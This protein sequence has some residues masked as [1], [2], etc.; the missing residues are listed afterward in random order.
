MR[1]PGGKGGSFR[2]L[3]NLM[4]RH[5]V[6]IETHL[7]GGAVIRRKR[8]VARNIGI[9]LDDRVAA[10]WKALDLPWLELVHGDAH[11]FLE[12]FP[13]A[14]SE[15]VFCDPPYLPET[16]RADRVYRYDYSRNDH[17]RLLDLL[18]G[19]PCQVMVCGYK[20]ALYDD[21]LSRWH[22]SDIHG[23]S[24]V[25]G[26]VD[27]V[28]TN[29]S[30]PDIPFDLQFAGHTYRERERIQRKHARLTQKIDGLDELERALLLDWL[31]EKYA[32][33]ASPKTGQP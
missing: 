2:R 18:R 33:P 10:R 25:G 32:F 6:Y 8:P 11:Q 9:E 26:R 4:P 19:L 22:V 17:I 1:Y 31:R 30:L 20:S 12:A 24:R 7:G 16:R 27:R 21:A 29:Y 5:S 3:V 15:L 13:F 28:W 14:G 23:A